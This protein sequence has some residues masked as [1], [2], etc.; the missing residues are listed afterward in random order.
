MK[1]YWEKFWVWYDRHFYLNL[2][3]TTVL[4]LFQLTHLYWLFTDVILLRLTGHSYF[5]ISRTIGYLIVAVDY[6]EIPVMVSAIILYISLLRKQFSWKNLWL[7]TFLNIHWLHLFWITDDIV[8]QT[9]NQQKG[10][11]HWTGLIAWVAILIDY[12]EIPIMID[13]VG[14]LYK[15]TKKILATTK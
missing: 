10:L 14:M 9:L 5:H 15:E 4:F 12:L 2:T 11:F 7:L 8:V 13:T 1:K 6:I 3:V